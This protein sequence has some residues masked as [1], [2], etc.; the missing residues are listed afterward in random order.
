V[1]YDDLRAFLKSLEAADQLARVPVEVDPIFEVAAVCRQALT[2]NGPG[3]LF[4]R[5]KGS[6]H[7]LATNLLA[8]RERLAIALGVEPGDIAACWN[9]GAGR[10]V[11]PVLRTDGACQELVFRD[12]DV[13]LSRFAV[14]TWNEE[15]GGPY[16]TFPCH[17]SRNPET[18]GLDCGMYRTQVFDRRTVA[19][20]ARPTKGINV[21][22]STASP[23]Q[24]GFPVAIVLGLDPVI[25]M[26]TVA[27]LPYGVS[28]LAVAGALR[29]APVELVPCVTQPLEV[30]ASAEIVLEGVV[31]ADTRK[32]GPFGE[33]HGYYGA[34]GMRSVIR[35]T[36]IT[37]R[38]D[39]INQQVY[40]G[41]PPQEDAVMHG[42][43]V[44]CEILRRIGLEGVQAVNVTPHS[45]GHLHCVVSVDTRLAEDGLAVAR[46]VLA[47]R[48][49]KLVT[50]VDAD[51]DV[52]D[53][54][55]VEWAVATRVDYGRDVEIIKAKADPA[56]TNG[57]PLRELLRGSKM[58]VDATR[59]S[60]RGFPREA[61]PPRSVIED[62]RRNWAAYGIN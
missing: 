1:A 46:A 51:V 20:N 26:T 49:V 36:A 59:P 37:C 13:D 22:R 61:R 30:P 35:L 34:G 58:I 10:S 25:H 3:L 27:N 57:E 11:E 54:G 53:P 24:D 2:T 50:V 18:G 56:L 48:G 5:V 12:D 45:G 6:P 8:T 60:G 16:I 29:G 15:D 43:I 7:R 40:E 9:A 38:H 21:N 44:A 32:E 39:A 41:R 55:E 33:Y 31:T 28:E 52:F 42:T 62:V 14:P 19:L 4:E 17:V 47:V 23:D